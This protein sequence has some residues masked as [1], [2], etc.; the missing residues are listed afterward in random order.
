MSSGRP[1]EATVPWGGADVS[2][3]RLGQLRRVDVLH[4][5]RHRPAPHPGPAPA[6][7]R[8]AASPAVVVVATATSSTRSAPAVVAVRP[9]AIRPAPVRAPTG[10]RA[11]PSGLLLRRADADDQRA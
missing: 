2:E 6:A 8:S 10:V 9:A 11:G 3:V 7:A 4:Q 1:R 5:L